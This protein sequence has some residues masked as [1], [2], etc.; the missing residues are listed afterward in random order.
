MPVMKKLILTAACLLG[1]AGAQTFPTAA[2][3]D[4]SR[5]TNFEEVRRIYNAMVDANYNPSIGVCEVLT[6]DARLV[7]ATLGLQEKS[8][9]KS[10]DA[11]PTP[12]DAERLR[13]HS[14][15][16]LLVASSALMNVVGESCGRRDM[17]SAAQGSLIFNLALDLSALQ[18]MLAGKP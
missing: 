5:A 15:R 3:M 1:A 14:V 17:T 7:N 2:Q 13:Y 12:T 16:N 11:L 8:L 4:A 9:G 10:L 18:W 6:R